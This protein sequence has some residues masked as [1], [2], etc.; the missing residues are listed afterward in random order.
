MGI[1][2][3]LDVLS[4]VNLALFIIDFQKA[5]RPCFAITVSSKKHPNVECIR[6]SDALVS[7]GFGSKCH[8][9]TSP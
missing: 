4:T 8:S 1:G 5:S 7:A 3:L 6:S 9:Q 2:N